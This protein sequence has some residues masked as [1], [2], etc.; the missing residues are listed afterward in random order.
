MAVVL[1][2]FAVPAVAEIGVTTETL[3]PVVS[4]TTLAEPVS[5]ILIA[6][7]TP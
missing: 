7:S 2:V 6:A 4:T 5:P 1:N 3:G